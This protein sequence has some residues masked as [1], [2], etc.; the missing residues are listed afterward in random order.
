MAVE[1][2]TDLSWAP[3]KSQNPAEP[4]VERERDPGGGVASRERW[5]TVGFTQW[6]C[7]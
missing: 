3:K 4:I 5:L 7:L 1:V 2:K 6:G